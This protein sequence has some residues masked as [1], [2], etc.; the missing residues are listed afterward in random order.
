M[1]GTMVGNTRKFLRINLSTGETGTETVPDKVIMDFIG[2]R[3]FGINYLYQELAP[4][5]DP[6]GKDNKLIILTGVLAGTSAQSVSRWMVCTKSP[7]TG[8]YA[9]SVAGAD[10]G[11][12]LKFA[13]YDFIIVEGKAQRPV[14]IHLTSDGCQINDAGELWGKDTKET[15]E[16][17]L[18]T[19]GSHTRVASIGPAGERLVKYAAIMI[20]GRAAARCGVGTVMGSKNL[21][22]IAI[23]AQRNLQLHDPVAFKQLVK[24]QIDAYRENSIYQ[25]HRAQGTT[26]GQ[27]ATNTLGVFPV[28]NFR[29]GQMIGYERISGREYEKIR[30]GDF[31]CYSCSARCGK[32]HFVTTGPY[33]G[34][35][36]DGGPEYETIR[37][38]TG[39]I[40][41]T[42]IGATVAADQ[43]CDDLGLDTIST[44]N[45]IGF[46]YELYEKGIITKQDTD[47]L[48]L[49][50]G[51]HAAMIT[52]IKKI[53]LREGFGNILAEG[54]MR[55][56]AIIGKGAEACAIHVKGLELPGYEPRG[57]KAMGFNF[58]TSNIGASHNYGYSS[59]G[60]FGR[61]VPRK[62]D[63]FAEE[64]NADIVIYNQNSRAMPEVGIVCTFSMSWGWF[65]DIFGKML[66]A[67]TGINQFASIDYL[68]KVGERIINLERAFNVREGFSR[69]QDTLPQRMLTE[70]LDTIGAPGDG[71]MI[72]DIDKFLDRYYQLRG[73]TPEGIPSRQK[74]EELGLGY[75][76]QDI[77]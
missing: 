4:G 37:A 47:G 28:K 23:T 60:V 42:E 41:S 57:V 26:Y 55:A 39:T 48:E 56:A 12:W 32:A 49:T 11:A 22:A 62:I 13:G 8:C 46:A 30:T 54:T 14:Y 43:L 38:F 29:Y 52:L 25:R 61:P 15:T 69:K 7:L 50:Y 34:T 67:A 68:G 73:W 27:D 66:A 3:G 45:C 65:P 19:H 1:E 16:K 51:N 76:L 33:A 9:R 21:K 72:R 18:Q 35:R 20:G 70:P 77:D 74:L 44:G 10:F 24:E 75:I 59:Q 71:Q 17:L 36:G 53:A 64:E 6:L 31:G 63:R 5:I 40:D 58:A 2:G